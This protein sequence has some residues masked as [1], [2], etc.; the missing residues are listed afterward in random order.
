MSEFHE[1]GPVTYVKWLLQEEAPILL[2]ACSGAAVALFERRK[3]RFAVFAAA[4]GFGLLAAYSI[5]K[6][7]TPWL[8]LSFVV[9]LAVAAGYCV[10]KFARWG[11]GWLTPALGLLG[12]AAAVCLFQ[13]YRLNFVNYDNDAYPYVYSH[14]RREA[15]A[16]VR[17]VGRVGALLGTKEPAVTIA[18]GE[19]WPLPWYFRDNHR[20]G[21][22]AETYLSYDPASTPVVI[23]R[24]G[25]AA[26][27]NTCAK[28]RP[29]LAGKYVEVGTYALRPGVDLVLFEGSDLAAR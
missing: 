12:L 15:V 25:G 7:K 19:Y 6:Y 13:T 10:Q 2:L 20:V 14:T 3:N 11:R 24:E 28:L 23:C 1:K 22:T 16:L 27:E 21:Y 4:W 29:L 17:E 26:A 9:P 5:I 18:S 8:V